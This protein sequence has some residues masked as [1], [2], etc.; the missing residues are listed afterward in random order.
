MPM[1][2]ILTQLTRGSSV[3]D[4]GLELLLLLLYLP[5]VGLTDSG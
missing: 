2:A 3:V 1:G 5:S 4:T